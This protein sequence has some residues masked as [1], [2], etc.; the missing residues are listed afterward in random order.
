MMKSKVQVLLSLALPLILATGCGDAESNESSGSGSSD[1][2][3]DGESDTAGDTDGDTGTAAG[4]ADGDDPNAPRMEIASDIDGDMTLGCD[5][6]WV[7][8]DIIFARNGAL[9]IEPGTTI[10]GT[11]GSALVIDQSATIDARG[12]E[13][14]PIVMTSIQAE[15]SR[16][17]GDWGGLVL[18]GDAPTNIEGGVGSAEGFANPPQYGGSDAGSNCGTL[19]YVR[20]EWAGFAIAEGS[21]LNGITFYACGTGTTVDHVQVHM[22]ADDGIEMFGGN[23]DADHLIVTGAED[24]SLDCDQ[25]F[26]G[27]LQYLFIQQD[28]SIGDN[29]F[30]WSNQGADFGAT[31]VTSPAVA[32]VTAIGSGPNGGDIKS[33]GIT[34]K[35]GTEGAI[36]NS[37]IG[38]VTNELM[39]ISNVETQ[40]IAERGG[41]EFSGNVWWSHGGFGVDSEGDITWGEPD[42]EGF[43][44]AEGNGN[45][46]ADPMLGSTAWGSADITPAAGS[47]AETAGQA[48]TGFEATTYS[49]AVEPGGENW[50]LA[51]WTNYEN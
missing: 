30:E 9:V 25:G 10:Q 48:V 23:F 45:M 24:D 40:E 39:L 17:R 16:N 2:A 6:V 35:E 50:T 13:D 7:V 1:S 21:E 22:G 34:L 4:C 51:A 19:S 33:K 29:L 36:F 32:N 47:P 3:S 20:V 44:M 38:N 49:G 42:F 8:T 27:N 18:L 37:L 26:Q 14:A 15:G 41:V 12:T 11:E 46:E 43:V 5:T 28:P 31:P